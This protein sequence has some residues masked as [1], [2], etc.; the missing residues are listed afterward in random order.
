MKTL[1]QIFAK[2]WMEVYISEEIHDTYS[3]HNP[4]PTYQRTSI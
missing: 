4:K 3:E 1:M 2:T